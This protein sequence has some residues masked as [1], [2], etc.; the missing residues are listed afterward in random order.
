MLHTN[1][2]GTAV[3]RI[4]V[5]T[6]DNRVW[7]IRARSF[8]LAC[9][10]L[11]NARLLLVSRAT[12]PRGLG[13]DRDIVGRFF[14]EHPYS[15]CGMAISQHSVLLPDR[16]KRLNGVKLTAG[17]CT[18]EV[19]QRREQCM[20]SMAII[21]LGQDVDHLFGI[22]IGGE[23]LPPAPEGR[24]RY[25]FI[26]QSEQSPKPE[27]RIMLSTERDRFGMPRSKLDWR[28][29]ELDK[30]SVEVMIK[31]IGSEYARLGFG[32]VRLSDWL[33]EPDAYW[34]VLAGNHHMGT[35]R[36]GDDP[37]SSVVDADSRVHGIDNLY[38]AG[39]SVFTTS[40][41]AN[42]TFTIVALAIRLADRIRTAA[43]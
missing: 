24:V 33:R 14:M 4:E 10:G 21:D 25:A 37:R 19:A 35:T 11:E 31:L 1:E 40:S 27:S 43:V 29:D 30:F 13:N 16:E 39:S 8:V 26:A 18:G 32:R 38:M 3:E 20:G 9:G 6:L 36:M 22:G 23:P 7:R 12:N 42:P 17:M 5:R 41:F 2:G 28:M 15:I 34:G